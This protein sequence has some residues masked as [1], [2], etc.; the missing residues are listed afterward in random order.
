MVITKLPSIFT[1]ALTRMCF[2]FQQNVGQTSGVAG[3]DLNVEPVW[4]QGFTGSGVVVT[5][6]DDGESESR[7]PTAE[8][9]LLTNILCQTIQTI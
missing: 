3:L 7:P 5:V 9:E 2:L 8:V 4:M 6:V 1:R